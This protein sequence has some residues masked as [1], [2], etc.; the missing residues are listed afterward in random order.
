M[1]NVPSRLPSVEKPWLKYYT[2]EMINT[3][4]PQG[5]IYE[6][7]YENNKDY[8]K[9]IAINYLG[10][11]ISY[12]ELFENIDST[13]AAL[14]KVGVKSGDIVTVALPSV[15]EALYLTY[16]LNKLG[17]VVN[18]IHPLAGEKELA[19]Y[20]NEA[21]S[22]IAIFFD[23]TYEIV[24]AQL[25]KTKVR[26][27]VIVSAGESLP[28]PLKPLFFLKNKRILLPDERTTIWWPD[29]I[30]AGKRTVIPSVKKDPDS[31]AVISHTGGTTGDPK[32]VMCSDRSV[33]AVILQMCLMLHMKRQ[34]TQLAVLPPFINYSLINSMLEPIALGMTA[35]LIPKY[36]PEKFFEYM[37]KYRPNIIASIPP[38][39]EALLSI[40]ASE[41]ID[42]SFLRAT[43]YGGEA[44][45]PL[46]EKAI[47]DLFKQLNAPYPL[48]KGIGMTELMGAATFTQCDY[49]MFKSVGTPQQ[50]TLCKIVEPETFRELPCGEDGE[51]CFGGPSLMIG[52]FHNKRA[53]DDAI[54]VHPDGI[55]WIHTGDLGHLGEDGQL[56]ITGRIK[57]IIMTKGSDGVITKIFPDR[58]EKIVNSHPAISLCCA[59]CVPDEMR[60]NYP[61]VYAEL[62]ENVTPSDQLV[63][64][65]RT[66]CHN[67]L[68]NYMIPDEIEFI[69]TLPRTSRGKVDF[70][71]LEKMNE[72]NAKQA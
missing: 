31:C 50:H 3:P 32:G 33:N 23:R 21:E 8:P 38:Y 70:R 13:A 27:S 44:M 5:T 55:R 63:K 66:Y 49:D 69:D 60:V 28:A 45:D 1:Q 36:E 39:W 26:L 12:K 65:I 46:N 61:K 4:L 41:H 62:K 37:K 64:D 40:P 71:A 59:I 30:K 17:A 53:T 20:L 18:M 16:A 56:Y 7:L 67:F 47:N 24:K 22:E 15:P 43:G 9:D 58:I 10:R 48:Q 34:E 29:F 42:L 68:P 6:Y 57:R 19:F 14:T 52:Y 72:E 54:K 25:P 35:I 51:I 2:D 11:K